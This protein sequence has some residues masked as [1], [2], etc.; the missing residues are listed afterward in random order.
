[1]ASKKLFKGLA[2]NIAHHS[3]SFLSYLHP[4]LGRACQAVNLSNVTLN[5]LGG[6]A[7]PD[8]VPSSKE[9]D[10]AI[11]AWRSRFQ[12]MTTKVGADFSKIQSA[13]VNFDFTAWKDLYSAD[14]TAELVLLDGTK[15]T[16]TGWRPE[17]Q[18]S[19]EEKIPGTNLDWPD[20]FLQ[21]NRGK[22]EVKKG[23]MERIEQIRD[24]LMQD[25]D[26]IGVSE[27]VEARDEYDRYVNQ[28]YSFFLKG[29]LTRENLQEYLMK[30]ATDK[31]GLT[32]TSPEKAEITAKK[33]GELLDLK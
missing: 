19:P 9:L 5:L 27:W 20:Q 28:I 2:Q 32:Q 3:E 33:I 14:A 26:P 15:Y 1:M 22:K 17:P 12:E 25:W 29:A 30:S 7:M 10:L 11:P 4:H 24:I 16:A 31:M 6:P 13:S 8:N 21:T 18:K 23:T